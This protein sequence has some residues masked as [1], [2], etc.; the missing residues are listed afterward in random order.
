MS[1]TTIRITQDT[2]DRI[3][4]AIPKVASD[5]NLHR[6]SR[7]QAAGVLLNKILDGYDKPEE[8]ADSQQDQKG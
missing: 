2:A 5:M 8:P 1:I 4:A 7:E 3:D 6:L